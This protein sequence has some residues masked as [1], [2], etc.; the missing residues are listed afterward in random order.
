MQQFRDA[1]IGEIRN[2]M[3]RLFP[4]VKLNGLGNPLSVGT[5]KFDKGESKGFAYMNLSGGEKAAFDLVL[6]VIIKKREFDDTVFFIDE[7]EAHMAS[8]LQGALLQELYEQIPDGSQLWIA[9]HSLGVMRKAR[10]L[11]KAKS[12]AVAFLDFEGL[13][14]DLPVVMRPTLPDRPFWKRAMQIALDDLAGYIAPERVILCEG[15]RLDGAA[16]FDAECYNEIF[17]REFPEVVFL[18]AGNSHE[19]QTDPRGIGQLLK[20]LAPSVSIDRLIDRDDNSEAEIRQ[21]RSAGINVLSLRTIESYLLADETL[22]LLCES[23]GKPE[24]IGELLKVKKDAI[25]NSVAAGGPVDDLKRV[26][27]DIYNAAKRLFPEHKLG[28]DRRA[29][30][31]GMCAHLIRPGTQIYSR[32]KADIFRLHE[33]GDAALAASEQNPALAS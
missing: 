7:P 31:K 28:S 33:A 14:F 13:N 27:G 20:A 17:Q 3:G 30:M 8:T 24:I 1:T 16:D 11:S 2:V 29:F 25:A 23:L 26:A 22:S 12:G 18:G 10:D 5:F 9:T 6:D 4:G 15:G 19:V 21:R 32:L